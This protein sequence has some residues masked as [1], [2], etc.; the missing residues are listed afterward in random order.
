M[1]SSTSAVSIWQFPSTP[2]LRATYAAAWPFPHLV[3]D[4]LLPAAS[5]DALFAILDDEPV[6][7][8]RADLYTFD[9]T[10]PEPTTA[11]FAEVRAE[12]AAT[13][14]PI[15]A[16]LAQRPCTRCDLRAYAYRVGDYL[17]PHTDHREHLERQVAFIY[18]LPSPEPP[19]GGELEL[20]ATDYASAR[21]IE[22]RGNRLVLFG[23]SDTSLHQVRE[24]TAGLRLSLAGWFYP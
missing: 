13:L 1:A 21:V 22:P 4:D 12:L 18:Y 5:I 24:V 11:A 10:A 19:V 20:F 9:A 15:V 7:R 16:D 8:Y 14:A 2:D 6:E 23:V 17:L 3:V